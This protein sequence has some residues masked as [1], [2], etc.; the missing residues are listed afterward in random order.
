MAR[1]FGVRASGLE[2]LGF[3]VQGSGFRGKGL[4]LGF[5]VQDFRARECKV[6]G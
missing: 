3:R 1:L 6:W 2:G 5:R 4:G